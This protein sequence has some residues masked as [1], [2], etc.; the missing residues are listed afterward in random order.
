MPIPVNVKYIDWPILDANTLVL[1]FIE[2]EKRKITIYFLFL[3]VHNMFHPWE[4]L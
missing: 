2:T 3:Y 4:G 1:L